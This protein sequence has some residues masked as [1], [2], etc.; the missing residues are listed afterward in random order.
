MY[1][2][3]YRHMEGSLAAFG[4]DTKRPVQDMPPGA[5]VSDI[6]GLGEGTYSLDVVPLPPTRRH[7]KGS[8]N[9]SG[10][11]YGAIRKALGNPSE[12][13]RRNFNRRALTRKG[14]RPFH[15]QP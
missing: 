5:K 2:H 1:K 8:E 6:Y 10:T 9:T 12:G 4:S 7:T 11:S 15:L 3:I 14:P 13:G